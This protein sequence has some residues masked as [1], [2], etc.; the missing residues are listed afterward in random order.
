MGHVEP[1][2]QVHLLVA[3]HA[4]QVTSSGQSEHSISD[5]PRAVSEPEPIITGMMAVSKINI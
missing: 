5:Q 1:P 4:G 2:G 3:G